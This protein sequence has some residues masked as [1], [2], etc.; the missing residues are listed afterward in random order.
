MLTL[1]AG[2]ITSLSEYEPP[3]VLSFK[4]PPSTEIIANVPSSPSWMFMV[5]APPPP[6]NTA[7]VFDP[8]RVTVNTPTTSTLSKFV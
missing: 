7:A 8:E 6:E 3:D 1:P 5:P 2:L 4:L